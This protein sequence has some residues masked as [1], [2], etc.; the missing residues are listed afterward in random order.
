MAELSALFER[1]HSMK[2]RPFSSMSFRQAL[3]ESMSRPPFPDASQMEH[4]ETKMGIPAS[5][6]FFAFF[7]RSSLWVAA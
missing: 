6:A 7:L 5:R 3:A 2:D 1:L 4:S